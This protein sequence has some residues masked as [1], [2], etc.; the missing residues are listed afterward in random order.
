MLRG[1]VFSSRSPPRRRLSLK[2]GIF[3]LSIQE[4]ILFFLSIHAIVKACRLMLFAWPFSFLFFFFLKDAFGRRNSFPH[5]PCF[6]DRA[7]IT[8]LS[9]AFFLLDSTRW[10]PS[11][12][13]PSL[14][15]AC[16]LLYVFISR[17]P[18]FHDLFPSHENAV[19]LCFWFPAICLIFSAGITCSIFFFLWRFPP[20]NPPPKKNH[21]KTPPPPPP[22]KKN[23][24]PPKKKHPTPPQNPTKKP[25]PKLIICDEPP[26]RLWRSKRRFHFQFEFLP[27]IDLLPL[28]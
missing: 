10:R 15:K 20:Q 4:T 22:P 3:S 13:M 26:C 21:K 19:R 17:F 24:P 14:F 12:V 23:P 7:H 18:D 28:L 25:P 2:S 8:S 9:K 16:L 11:D 6:S 27:W 5:Q 1:P